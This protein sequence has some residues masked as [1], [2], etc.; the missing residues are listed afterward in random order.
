MS[1]LSAI[2]V[3]T[4]MTAGSP[5]NEIRFTATTPDC[6]TE[7]AIINGV[8]QANA[9]TNVRFVARCE[10]VNSTTSNTSTMSSR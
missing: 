5:T 7:L 2:L 4:V 10:Q 3:V 1:T 6:Q 8:N 9:N